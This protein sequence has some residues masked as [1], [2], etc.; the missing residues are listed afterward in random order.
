VF[1]LWGVVMKKFKVGQRITTSNGKILKI[2]AFS[3]NY[4]MVRH[5]GC[6]PFVIQEK[7]IEDYLKK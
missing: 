1:R 4:Y 5:P 3:E 2:M 7:K 6:F